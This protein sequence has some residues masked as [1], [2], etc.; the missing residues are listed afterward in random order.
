[1][2]MRVCVGGVRVVGVKEQAFLISLRL[3]VVIIWAFIYLNAYAGC[4]ASI[5]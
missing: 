5:Q 2:C 4:T 3:P 1:M